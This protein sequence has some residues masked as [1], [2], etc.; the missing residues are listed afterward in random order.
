MYMHMHIHINY[1]KLPRYHLIAG[2]ERVKLVIRSPPF[3]KIF[4]NQKLLN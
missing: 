3:S 1:E 2:R 4:P